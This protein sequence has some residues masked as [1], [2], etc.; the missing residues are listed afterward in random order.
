M[1]SPNHSCSRS[2]EV[3]G[4]LADSIARVYAQ[5]SMRLTSVV[6]LLASRCV[7]PVHVVT[8]G[9]SGLSFVP[10]TIMVSVGDYVQYQFFSSNHSMQKR[11]MFICR[12]A[13]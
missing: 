12:A 9:Q 5:E 10:D 8:V 1:P 3:S 7:A 13:D 4:I 11:N 6:L 2:C